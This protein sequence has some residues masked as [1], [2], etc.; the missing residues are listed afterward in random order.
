MDSAPWLKRTSLPP[1]AEIG[2][3]R[4]GLLKK[5]PVLADQKQTASKRA[6]R[7]P[8]VRFDKKGIPL[9]EVINVHRQF[10]DANTLPEN[11]GDGFLCAT[12]PIYGRVR[13]EYRKRG[14]S[15]T[16]Q[17]F[18]HY[19]SFPLMALDDL[20]AAKMVPYHPNFVWLEIMEKRSSGKFSLTE[21][22]G[23]GLKYNYVF[24]E[25]AHLIAHSIF[26]GSTPL[27]R[28]PKTSDSLL[29]ILLGEAFANTV[30]CMSSIFAAG[31]IG[32]YFLMAN[33]H[34]QVRG[35]E[36]RT[37]REATQRNGFEAVTKAI[38]ASFLYANFMYGEL[39]QKELERIFVFSGCAEREPIAPLAKIAFQLSLPF[40]AGT[41]PLHLTKIGFDAQSLAKL[42]KFDPLERILK[43]ENAQLREKVIG[44][45]RML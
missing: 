1:P 43:K 19:F 44:L 4:G 13:D 2:H 35:E 42:M 14:F 10:S 31:A 28:I 24:H 22:K 39:S 15:F 29:K 41:T 26:F 33:C 27:K 30:E 32:D 18:C 38:M 37:L 20:I 6:K 40:R 8:F 34:F 5:E 45:A 7:I 25:S 36:L 16:Q 3:P 21:L 12:N 17:D 23:S 11:L 9:R